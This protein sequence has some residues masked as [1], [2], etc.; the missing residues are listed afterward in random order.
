M[1][2][3]RPVPTR[4]VRPNPARGHVTITFG[5]REGRGQPFRLGVYD[6]RGRLVADFP[7]R[8]LPEGRWEMFWDRRDSGGRRVASGVY[9]VAMRVGEDRYTRRLVVLD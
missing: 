8:R 3:R 4:F 6:V 1:R 9:F 2:K 7:R 5:I